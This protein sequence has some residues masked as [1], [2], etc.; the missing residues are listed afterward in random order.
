VIRDAAITVVNMD[1]GIRRA[2]R[3]NGEGFYAV[4][5]L[6]AGMYK[7]TIRKEG[8]QTLRAWAYRCKRRRSADWTSC[9]TSAAR[10][11]W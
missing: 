5:S 4:S 1:T 7:L 10:K 6:S 2:V 11:R 3:S 9:S 8:F